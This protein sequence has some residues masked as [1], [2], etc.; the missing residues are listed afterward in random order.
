MTEPTI[1]LRRA[2][3]TSEPALRFIAEWAQHVGAAQVQVIDAADDARLVREALAAGEVLP[4]HGD[5][6]YARSH[7]KDTART[8]ERTFVATADPRDRGVYNNWQP[9][10][11]IEIGRAHV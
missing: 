2:G 11:E 1:E 3:L 6:I 4:V 9:S 7:P 8:E 5:R 10:G